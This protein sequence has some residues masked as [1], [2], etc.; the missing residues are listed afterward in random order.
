[1]NEK[2]EKEIW[3]SRGV[4]QD[5]VGSLAS[6]SITDVYVDLNMRVCVPVDSNTHTGWV[7]QRVPQGPT[8]VSTSTQSYEWHGGRVGNGSVI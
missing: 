3:I 6:S 1:M 7:P 4:E 5:R 2:M 8:E